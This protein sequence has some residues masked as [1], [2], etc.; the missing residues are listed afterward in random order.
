MVAYNDRDF[1]YRDETP[2]DDDIRINAHPG[3]A[4]VAH[5]N[6]IVEMQLRC[7]MAD[8]IADISYFVS[9]IISR[10]NTDCDRAL[11]DKQTGV[12]EPIAIERSRSEV[13]RRP[14]T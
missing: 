10:T 4:V 5:T 11:S 2:C 3:G 1:D 14:V 13:Y 8:G 9:A 6:T 7:A 12:C